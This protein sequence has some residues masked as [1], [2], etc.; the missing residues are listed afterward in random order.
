MSECLGCKETILDKDKSII[1]S[2]ICAECNE[3]EVVCTGK[4]TYTQCVTSNTTLPCIDTPIG[5]TQTQINQAFDTKLCQI[6]TGNCTVSVS[7]DDDCCGYLEDKILDGVGT[8]VVQGVAGRN[9]EHLKINV[10][11]YVYTNLSLTAPWLNGLS[12]I[13]FS[14]TPLA[15]GTNGTDVIRLKGQIRYGA[16]LPN[17]SATQ[18]GILPIGFRPAQTKYFTVSAFPSG[19]GIINFLVII[20][21][22]VGTIRAVGYYTGGNPKDVTLSLDFI[23]FTI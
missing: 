4:T 11:P 13:F 20:D 18:V 17:G 15:V 12:S 22:V 1:G 9:C 23:N 8:T 21:G 7:A 2:P 5:A 3:T 14:P 19:S 6:S 16:G 10:N